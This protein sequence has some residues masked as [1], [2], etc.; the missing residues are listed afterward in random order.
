M[1][2]QPH[3][4]SKENLLDLAKAW[5]KAKFNKPGN[6]F[7]EPIHRLDQ[8]VSGLVVFARTSKA[9]SRLQEEMRRGSIEKIYHA[10]LD[11]KPP[12]LEGTLEHF[13]K[14]G[15]HRAHV[16]KESDHQAK[17]ACLHYKVM[18]K[19]SDGYIE[20][21]I[22]LKT[23]RYHQI[24]AQMAF[25]GCPIVGDQKYGS[26]VIYQKEGIALM[27]KE[28]AF[29]HPTTKERLRFNVKRAI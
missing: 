10:L 26:R 1:S 28:V 20:V 18:G 24:R 17:F 2:T 9:L 8:S 4:N 3:D 25:I 5:I 16:V 13:L 29:F 11:K 6:V 15:N 7:L 27:H 21:K 12:Q 23:G 14:H 22:E 19:R